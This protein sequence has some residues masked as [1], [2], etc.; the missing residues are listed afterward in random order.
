MASSFDDDSYAY[1][2]TRMPEYAPNIY[3]LFVLSNSK[4]CM[5]FM[6]TIKSLNC[7]GADILLLITCIPGIVTPYTKKHV[8][9]IHS[10]MQS[11]TF[12]IHK[13]VFMT[14]NL[15]VVCEL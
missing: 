6:S 2:N 8:N 1:F 10:P 14:Y 12:L 5:I 7:D 11:R 15:V 3:G 13:P 4:W 9:N